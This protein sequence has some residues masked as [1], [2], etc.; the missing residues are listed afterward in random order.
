MKKLIAIL[1]LSTVAAFAQIVPTTIPRSYEVTLSM[2]VTPEES[3]PLTYQWYKDNRAIVDQ[4]AEFW[5][6][7]SMADADAG[8]YYCIAKNPLGEVQSNRVTLILPVVKAVS[9]ALKVD[10]KAPPAPVPAPAPA[11]VPVP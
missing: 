7:A 2:I 9:A 8:T 6:I 1:L 10:A 11:P 3:R 4:K 5:L